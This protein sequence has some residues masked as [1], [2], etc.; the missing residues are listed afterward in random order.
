M[1]THPS[2]LYYTFQAIYS[3][4]IQI[5]MI[6]NT[7]QNVCVCFNFCVCF[8][9]CKAVTN[10]HTKKIRTVSFNLKEFKNKTLS[11]IHS[12]V[13]T[14]FYTLSSL[15]YERRANTAKHPHITTCTAFVILWIIS[16]LGAGNKA[17]LQECL[18]TQQ[19]KVTSSLKLIR[20]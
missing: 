7:G 19:L 3:H 1:G 12:S 18:L 4:D 2:K 11:S 13:I 9:H 10:Y 8:A 5:G 14:C 20:V 15:S 6:F 17:Q 16:N